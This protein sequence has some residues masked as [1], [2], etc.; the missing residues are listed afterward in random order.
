MTFDEIIKKRQKE[1]DAP[2]MMDP[3]KYGASGKIPFSSPLLNWALYGGIPRDRVTEMYGAPGGGKST[4]AADLCINA[5]NLFESEHLAQLD[6]L[7]ER[8]MSGDKKASIALQDL[9]ERGPKKIMYV[10]IEHGFDM[11]WSQTLGMDTDKIE[12]MQ[13]PNVPAEDILQTVEDLICTGEVG[14]I[15][16]D[17]IPS[18]ITNAELEK[19]YGERTVASLA[20]LMTVFMRKIVSLL[21]RYGCTLVLINQLRKNLENQYVDQ[22]PGGEAVKFY[23]SLRLKFQLDSPLDF[24]GN[25]LPKSIEN[26]AGYIVNVKVMKQKTAPFDRKNATYYLMCQTGIRPDFDFAHLASEKYGIIQKG[27]A[28]Y[29]MCDPY[30]GEILMDEDTGKPVKLNGLAKV[31]DFL[32]SNEKYY[33]RLKEYIIAD[34]NGQNPSGESD[35]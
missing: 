21:T 29:T 15:V 8:V 25:T 18:L 33:N 2:D 20:G 5:I 19:K 16:L 27:G 4:S 3:T 9:E 7:R 6:A 24:L 14:L 10:D 26:P 12:I 35:E 22:T 17:S 30:T 23:S 13:P 31:Y 34:I 32:A 28:W 11:K 1:W